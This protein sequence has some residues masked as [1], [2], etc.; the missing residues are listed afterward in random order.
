MPDNNNNNN[1]NQA[2][3]GSLHHNG[4]KYAALVDARQPNGR[5]VPVF[6]PLMSAEN[7]KKEEEYIER[8]LKRE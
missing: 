5:F 1:N 2:F 3:S 7:L 6:A 8:Q 4:N